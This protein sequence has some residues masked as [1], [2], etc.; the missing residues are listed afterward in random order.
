MTPIPPEV[1]LPA[2]QNKCSESKFLMRTFQGFGGAAASLLVLTLVTG[3]RVGPKY[4]VP[5]TAAATAPPAYKEVPN[6]ANT[7]AADA[8]NPNAWK[9]AQPQ[10]AMLHGK[11]WE[12]FNDSDLNALEDKLNIDNQNIKQYFENFMEAR[13][14]VGEARSQ[15]YPTLTAGPTYTRSRSSSNLTNAIGTTG[16]GTT[17]T[18]G[19]TGTGT[20]TGTGVTTAT[21]TGR[22]SSIGDLPPGSEL[23]AGPLGAHPQHHPQRSVQRPGLRRRSRKRA[24]HRAGEPRPVL[25]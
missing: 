10:D 2:M 1:Q 17:G 7:D 20:G 25:L 14:L 18:T 12:I 24:P 16:T 4:H 19:G 8:K 23:G 5:P 13:A 21:T 9:V 22:Q 6:P 15:L 3:C 11:W